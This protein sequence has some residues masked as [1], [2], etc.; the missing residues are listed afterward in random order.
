MQNMDSYSL[1]IYTKESLD[2]YNFGIYKYLY[3]NQLINSPTI[4]KQFTILFKLLINNL[5]SIISLRN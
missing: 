4:N 5:T 2:F 3:I 1:L